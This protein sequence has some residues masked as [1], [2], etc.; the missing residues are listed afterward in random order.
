MNTYETVPSIWS[1]EM[2]QAAKSVNIVTFASPS[3]VRVWAQRVGTASKAVVIGPS[4]A[5]AA[6]A[7]GFTEII[8]PEGS[9]GLEAWAMLITDTARKLAKLL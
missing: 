4:S 1:D 8:S 9:K 2:L 3:A 7:A 6:E 5:R